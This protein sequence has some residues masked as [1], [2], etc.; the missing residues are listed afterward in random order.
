M[1]ASD[2]IALER[3]SV[4]LNRVIA[5]AGNRPGDHK[6]RPYIGDVVG[7]TLVVGPGKTRSGTRSR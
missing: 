6:G 7:A 3:I 1:G 2:L 4:G 5:S